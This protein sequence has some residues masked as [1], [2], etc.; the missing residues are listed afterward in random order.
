MSRVHSVLLIGA[1]LGAVFCTALNLKSPRTDAGKPLVSEL[2]SVTAAPP[3]PGL[4]SARAS[5]R[6]A[7]A[8]SADALS[9]D[10][11]A[12]SDVTAVL[13]GAIHSGDVS[14]REAAF[15]QTLA[16]WAKLFPVQAEHVVNELGRESPD[17]ARRVS[18]QLW[19][20]RDFP[21]AYQWAMR[22]EDPAERPFLLASVLYQSAVE[23]PQATLELAQETP[24]GEAREGVLQTLAVEWAITDPVAAVA[25]ATAQPATPSRDG[26]FRQIALARLAS[27]PV[28]AAHLILYAISPGPVQQEAVSAAL[29]RWPAANHAKAA[30]WL[31][32]FPDGALR[33]G[34][35]ARLDSLA[36]GSQ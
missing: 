11:S 36:I 19:A 35:E 6:E 2:S 4:A 33:R 12:E 15:S 3:D 27:D 7:G 31:R 8:P 9:P 29:E 26:I 16:A 20:A 22:F 5:G 18:A 10:D 34:A 30:E 25:W 24:L 13:R 1:I 17:A 28:E 21:A 23:A 14:A 32:Q